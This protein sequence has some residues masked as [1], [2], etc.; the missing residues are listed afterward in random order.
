MI[1]SIPFAQIIAKRR[2]IDLF[3][4]GSKSAG[5]TNVGRTIGRTAGS[6]VFGLDAIKGFTASF[7][8]FC[9]DL[10]LIHI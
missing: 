3:K 7:L 8:T 4:Q 1:G 9:F 5:A 6:I 2:G 10:S